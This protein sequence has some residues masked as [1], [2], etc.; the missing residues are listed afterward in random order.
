MDP[1]LPVPLHDQVSALVGKK[2]LV[3]DDDAAMLTAVSKV[4]RH[5]GALVQSA[6]G[7]VEAISLL[8]A[9]GAAFHA[10][11]TDLRMPVASG[12]TILSAIKTSNPD[13]PVVVMSAFW[14]DEIKAEC[15]ELGATSVLDKPLNSIRLITAV[16]KA[17]IGAYKPAGGSPDASPPAS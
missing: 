4:L 2:L 15:V 11:L 6:G 8:A 7:V 14:T 12:K 10:V 3:V 16:S 13:V 1:S 17:L 5:A 9:D